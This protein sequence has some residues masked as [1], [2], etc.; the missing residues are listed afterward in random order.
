MDRLWR[1]RVIA[2]GGR[3]AC[4]GSWFMQPMADVSPGLGLRQSCKSLGAKYLA[5][6]PNL[7]TVQ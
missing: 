3:G 1:Q 7:R 4:H 2:P 5:T 6:P